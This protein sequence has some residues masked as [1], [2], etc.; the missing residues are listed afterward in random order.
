MKVTPPGN[1]GFT[2][3]QYGGTTVK[4]IDPKG[5]WKKFE[6]NSLGNLITVWEPRPGGGADYVTWFRIRVASRGDQRGRTR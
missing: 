3:Y 1:A 5:K 6:N 4:T 2:S